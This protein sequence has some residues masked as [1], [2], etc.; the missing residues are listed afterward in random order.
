MRRTFPE[1]KEPYNFFE[2]ETH[3]KLRVAL[4]AP[5]DQQWSSEVKALRFGY[6]AQPQVDH[7]FSPQVW[8]GNQRT[9]LPA[10][11]DGMRLGLGLG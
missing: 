8:E 5:H 4:H 2:E 3:F 10:A 6:Y 11:A 9:T 1:I 7:K